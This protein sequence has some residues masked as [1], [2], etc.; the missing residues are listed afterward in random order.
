MQRIAFRFFVVL[1]RRHQ[2]HMRRVARVSICLQKGAYRRAAIVTET[3]TGVA[4]SNLPAA[5]RSTGI[6]ADAVCIVNDHCGQPQDAAFDSAQNVE[7]VGADLNCG[8]QRCRLHR[9]APSGCGFVA[10][11]SD[12]GSRGGWYGRTIRWKLVCPGDGA[13]LP[14]KGHGAFNRHRSAGS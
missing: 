6:G 2:P 11:L 8:S 3:Q 10:E 13:R 7:L 5:F 4:K 12:G 9:D 1:T 14:R